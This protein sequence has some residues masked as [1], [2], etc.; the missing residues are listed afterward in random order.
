MK[1]LCIE[2]LCVAIYGY[3]WIGGLWIFFLNFYNYIFIF[4]DVENG[5]SFC[6]EEK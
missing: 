6:F 3:C 4:C 1:N 5:S 2:M